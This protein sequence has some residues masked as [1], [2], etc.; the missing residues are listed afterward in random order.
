MFSIPLSGARASQLSLLHRASCR[1]A[2][3]ATIRAVLVWF[4]PHPEFSVC[5]FLQ[6]GCKQLQVL[7]QTYKWLNLYGIEERN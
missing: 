6:S 7:R 1:A 3:T 4:L 5:L 2:Q